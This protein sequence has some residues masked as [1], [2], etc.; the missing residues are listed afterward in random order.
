MTCASC[1]AR[2]ERAL[3]ALPDVVDVRAS[4]AAEA[5]T[6]SVLPG[7]RVEDA[8]GALTSAGYA[9]RSSEAD[10]A[11]R[12]AGEAPWLIALALLAA[13]FLAGMLGMAFGQHWMPSGWVQAAL[14]TPIQF[15][16]GARFYRAGIAAARAGAGNM[17][18]LVA[19]GTSAAYLLSLWM[20]LTGHD[21]HHLYFEASSLV[22]AFV[23]LGRFLERRA[24]RAT[25]AAIAALLALAPRDARR[26]RQDGSEET[27]PVEFLRVDDLVV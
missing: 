14:A 17:D 19:I 24:K 12:S 18:L 22:I 26:L 2:V 5:A 20:L 7:F 4:V 15:L 1:A 23:W 27:I 13:P 3:S 9:L 6:L 25:G 16:F 11:P 8:T 21:A 10:R